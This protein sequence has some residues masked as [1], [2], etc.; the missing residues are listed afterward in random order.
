MSTEEKL[1][2]VVEVIRLVSR[3][4]GIAQK[5]IQTAVKH[6]S[7]V[8]R[9]FFARR[10]AMALCVERGMDYAE[11]AEAFGRTRLAVCQAVDAAALEYRESFAF[12]ILWHEM[13]VNGLKPSRL[14]NAGARLRK[15]A[16][17]P[18]MGKAA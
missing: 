18:R 1:R 6:T 12:Q 2:T 7:K 17:K 4:T 3:R 8:D 13:A 10:L 9:G 14:A 15:A 5:V 11:T 16:M